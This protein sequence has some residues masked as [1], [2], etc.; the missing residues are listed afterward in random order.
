L[1]DER[2]AFQSVGESQ[3]KTNT[4]VAV[5]DTT[6][7]RSSDES[8]SQSVVNYPWLEVIAYIRRTTYV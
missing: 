3:F 6:S 1:D 8:I 5:I 4:T 7:E 2:F